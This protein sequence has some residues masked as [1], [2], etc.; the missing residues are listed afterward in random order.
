MKINLLILTLLVPTNPPQS[1]ATHRKRHRK[2]YLIPREMDLL[3]KSS[4]ARVVTV[5]SAAHAMSGKPN[6]GDME[7]K[8]HY[9]MAKAYAVSKLYVIWIM[10][11]FVSEIKKYGIENITFN[12]VHPGSAPTNLGRESTKS[13]KFR[14]ILFLWKPMMTTVAKAAS[15]SIKA[16]TSPELE[17]VTGKYYGLKGEEKPK[18]KYYSLENEKIV[19]DYCMNVVK[20][21]L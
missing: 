4:S 1:R 5:S 3:K 17:G 15:S 19:W 12:T 20:P 6:L 14:I 9:S 18:D 8:K 13:L 2:I 10:R 7:L 21:Y 16:A 11:H